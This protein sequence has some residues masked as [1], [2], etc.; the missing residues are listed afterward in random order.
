[1]QEASILPDTPPALRLRLQAPSLTNGGVH[2][3]GVTEERD[4]TFR[5]TSCVGGVSLAGDLRPSGS[6]EWR[7]NLTIR[8]EGADAEV[9]VSYPY[10]FGPVDGR[11]VL[12]LRTHG[13]KRQVTVRL[14]AGMQVLD[15]QPTGIRRVNDG[16]LVVEAH[17]EPGYFALQSMASL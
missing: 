5:W 8:N 17:V 12:A 9:R 3:P 2:S 15:P 13:E 7:R 1:M 4:G 6:G 14:P 16:G 11:G 10:L